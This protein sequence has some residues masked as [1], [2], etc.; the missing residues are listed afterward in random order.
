[1]RRLNSEGI[2]HGLNAPR[3]GMHHAHP[4]ELEP[5]SG[6]CRGMGVGGGGAPIDQEGD[7]V[8][9]MRLLADGHAPRQHLTAGSCARHRH[10][11]PRIVASSPGTD[12]RAFEV[13]DG[14][15]PGR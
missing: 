14:N 12:E 10:D 1:M 13:T 3:V 4:D 5:W 6:R 2:Q 8:A 15:R 9:A 11:L 7:H